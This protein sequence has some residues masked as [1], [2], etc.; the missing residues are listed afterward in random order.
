MRCPSAPHP[1]LLFSWPTIGLT[2][3]AAESVSIQNISR[4]WP[5]VPPLAP[6]SA[7]A[8]RSSRISI[9]S[10]IMPRE[11]SFSELLLE[12]LRRSSPLELC[13]KDPPVRVPSPPD[14][15]TRVPS[16]FTVRCSQRIGG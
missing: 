1:F 8:S 12:G 4:T 11:R 2:C 6:C 9:E 3:P 14:L 10:G 15:R 13:T 5:S 16:Y 7:A